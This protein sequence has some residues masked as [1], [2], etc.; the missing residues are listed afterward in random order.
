MSP[1][2]ETLEQ[3]T[4][5]AR[6]HFMEGWRLLHQNAARGGSPDDGDCSP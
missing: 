4:P 1:V 5:Q 6:S 3:L 2:R